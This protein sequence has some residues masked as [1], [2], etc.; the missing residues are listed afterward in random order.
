MIT[1]IYYDLNVDYVIQLWEEFGNAITH[2]NLENGVSCARYQSLILKEVDEQEG[3][4]VPSQD[5][6]AAFSTIA[7]QRLGVDDLAIFPS[8]ARIPDAML[9]CI[10][11]KNPLL[12][13]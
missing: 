4:L 5:K 8:V 2:T 9:R 1:G 10:G 6:K 11:L 3:I 13:Q 7:A 12:I